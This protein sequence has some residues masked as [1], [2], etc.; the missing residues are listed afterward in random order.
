VHWS[1]VWQDVLGI[2]GLVCCL[3]YVPGIAPLQKYIPLISPSVC[4]AAA[5]FR[6]VSVNHVQNEEM[7][8]G[9]FEFES[10]ENV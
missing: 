3:Y 4:I 5:F 9:L 1:C 10:L 8:Y 6:P 7:L 2:N